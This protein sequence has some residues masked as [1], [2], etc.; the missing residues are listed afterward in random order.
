MKAVDDLVFAYARALIG[1]VGT[2]RKLPR[3]QGERIRAARAAI[4]DYVVKTVAKARADALDEA[5]RVPREY[6]TNIEQYSC[7]HGCEDN[8]LEI[9]KRIFALVKVEQIVLPIERA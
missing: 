8:Y 4:S 2:I 6:Y 7:E 3:E 5:A 1:D 9:E